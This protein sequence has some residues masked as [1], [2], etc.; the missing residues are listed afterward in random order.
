MKNMAKNRREIDLLSMLGLHIL[1]L[2]QDRKMSQIVLAARAKLSKTYLSDLEN[3]RR[4]PS[5]VILLRIADA[6]QITVDE[7]FEG[8]TPEKREPRREEGFYR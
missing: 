8:C 6:L 5:A 2:R 7:L 4:K 1:E 3:G